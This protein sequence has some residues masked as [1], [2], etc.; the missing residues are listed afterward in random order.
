[1]ATITDI[2]APSVVTGIFSRI[3][4]PA[5]PISQFF[6]VQIG[7]GNIQKVTGR[8]YSYDLL[9]NVRTIAKGRAPGTGP[10]THSLAPV[11]NQ[12]HTIPRT[13][14]KTHLSYEMLHNIRTL[15]K[16]AGERDRMGA[17][18]LRRQAFQQKLRQDHFREFLIARLITAGTA[19]FKID[20]DDWLPVS[21]LGSDAGYTIDWLIP[22]GNKST[23][24][25]GLNPLGTGNIIDA[26]WGTAST[27]VPAH[28][29]KIN[30][31]FQQL[32][33]LPLALVVTDSVVWNHVLN[34]T[35][36]QAQGGSVNS[37]F[38]E[39][40][41]DTSFKTPEGEVINVFAA[42]LRAR[43]WIRW[44][45]V[46]T[47]LE[48]NG[49]YT[50]W[51]DGTKATFM[52]DHKALML[53]GVEGSEPVKENPAAQAVERYGTFAWLREWDEPARVE[54]HS[55]QNFVL[56]LPIPKGIMQATVVA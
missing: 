56:Q 25:A 37:V 18:Y 42:R 16:H 44:L 12:T 54:L 46:D 6:G 36:L 33:G 49:T 15:G 38:A 47:G 26:S 30:L 23:G 7:G 11:G 5:N 9:D 27:D 48:I 4:T 13:Y 17:E 28:L 39:Y 51:F 45:I 53:Q 35:K 41:V 10:A 34:N 32:V 31:A 52:V 1:M 21:S 43:P 20:G 2:L 50:R 22:S 19:S 55:L 24:I 40:D 8:A 3:Y 14:E 29:D